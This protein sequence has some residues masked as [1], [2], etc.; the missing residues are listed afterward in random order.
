[1][2]ANE[3]EKELY[4]RIFEDSKTLTD[5]VFKRA[6]KIYSERVDGECVA[7]I[8]ATD[9]TLKINNRK[10]KIKFLS[11]VC[12]DEKVR[13]KGYFKK[14]LKEVEADVLRENVFGIM[15]ATFNPAIYE[16]FNYRIIKKQSEIKCGGEDATYSLSVSDVAFMRNKYSEYLSGFDAGLER[17]KSYYAGLDE[18]FKQENLFVCKL[19]LD[20]KN[21]GYILTDVNGNIEETTVSVFDLLRANCLSGM[22][23]RETYFMFK[24]LSDDFSVSGDVLILDVYL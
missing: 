12:T 20:G 3:S 23:I 18:L 6:A 2:S 11:G 17:P 19:N 22:K 24:T 16:K 15:L 1:M 8:I 21:L 10:R 14:L 5:F 13:G 7:L 4:E 9:K